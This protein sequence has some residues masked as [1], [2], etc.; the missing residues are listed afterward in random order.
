LTVFQVVMVVRVIA[1]RVIRVKGGLR[2]L[3]SN[4]IARIYVRL[5]QT[6][7]NASRKSK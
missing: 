7:R 3:V 1:I 4:A 5:M 6:I 2:L